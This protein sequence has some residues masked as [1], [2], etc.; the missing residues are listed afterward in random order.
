M[1]L[2]NKYS[3]EPSF[4]AFHKM[5]TDL[6]S[7]TLEAGTPLAGHFLRVSKYLKLSVVDSSYTLDKEEDKALHPLAD[8]FTD[9]AINKEMVDHIT[10]DHIIIP[11]NL[12]ETKLEVLIASMKRDFRKGMFPKVFHPFFHWRY[13]NV[14]IEQFTLQQVA[15]MKEALDQM[16][17]QFE[18]KHPSAYD[19]RDEFIVDDPWQATRGFGEDKRM[20]AYL[21]YIDDKLAEMQILI[22][23]IRKLN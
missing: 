6:L 22:S 13:G 17:E 8:F 15:D 2:Y 1:D 3:Y 9:G 16:I 7:K 20:V 19:I 18:D 4:C 23:K 11:I 5:V 12:P 14:N 10:Y 21:Q